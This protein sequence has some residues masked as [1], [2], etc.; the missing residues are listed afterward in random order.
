MFNDKKT[1]VNTICYKLKKPVQYDSGEPCDRFLFLVSYDTKENT[2]K[3]VDTINHERPNEFYRNEIN[4]N[5]IEYFY[6]SEREAF[7]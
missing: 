5:E 3:M 7:Y 6:M 4:W 2:Q 1:M